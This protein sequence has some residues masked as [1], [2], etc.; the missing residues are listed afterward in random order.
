MLSLAYENQCG[1]SLR[2]AQSLLANLQQDENATYNANYA[3]EYCGGVAEA[4]A[5]EA[6]AE[7]EE[8]DG[9]VELTPEGGLDS[10]EVTP[11]PEE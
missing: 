1:E 11:T 6:A 8:G 4:A 9:P 3:I 10:E 7:D 2:V 5:E